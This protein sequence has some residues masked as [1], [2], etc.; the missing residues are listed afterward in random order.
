MKSTC[1]DGVSGSFVL[2]IAGG[3]PGLA[4]LLQEAQAS[5]KHD[6]SGPAVHNHGRLRPL[7]GAETFNVPFR[8]LRAIRYMT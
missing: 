1:I 7:R 3:P 8:R 5:E 4:L 6:G 2:S